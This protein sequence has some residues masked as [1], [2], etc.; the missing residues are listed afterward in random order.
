MLSLIA[1]QKTIHCV[2]VTDSNLSR[3]NKQT[4]TSTPVSAATT[5]DAKK[6]NNVAAASTAEVD[7]EEREMQQL[8]KEMSTS[9]TGGAVALPKG[10]SQYEI[11]VP[12]DEKDLFAYYYLLKVS[13]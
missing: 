8:L 4:T 13:Y 6:T 3:L 9:V 5:T 10:L 7:E 1:V 11:K 2:D 12:S